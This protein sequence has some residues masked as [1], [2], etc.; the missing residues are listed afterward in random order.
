MHVNHL[1]VFTIQAGIWFL[2]GVYSFKVTVCEADARIGL[3]VH[4]CGTFTRLTDVCSKL[5]WI[6]MEA[7]ST[8]VT[9]WSGGVV[10]AVLWKEG[11]V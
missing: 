4:E 8:L 2:V 3:L 9:L 6:Q 7:W 11:I 10:F 5:I 1:L